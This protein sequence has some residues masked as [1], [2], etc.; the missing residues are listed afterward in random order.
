MAVTALAGQVVV[1]L[2]I[3]T[4]VGLV[5][6]KGDAL[7][8]EPVNGAAAV[9]NG[10]THSIFIAQTCPGNQCILHMGLNCIALIK[11]AGNTTLGPVG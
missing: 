7:L 6:G 11:H 10:E 4:G 8:N 3:I 9:F 1:K 2:R 5:A